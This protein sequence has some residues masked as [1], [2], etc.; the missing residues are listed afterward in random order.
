MKP[1]TLKELKSTLENATKDELVAYC[2]QLLKFKKENKELLTYVLYEH[3]NIPDFIKAVCENVDTFFETI[4]ITHLYFVKKTIRKIIRI[5]NRN[6]KYSK[7]P[8]VEIEIL[9]HTAEKIKAL[10]LPLHQNK[11]LLNIYNGLHSK[12]EKVLSTVHPDEQYDYKKRVND[13]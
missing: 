8:I 4:N 11:A 10:K 1:A 6:I 3:N 7:Q 2:L 9:L 5:A 12:I 13:L